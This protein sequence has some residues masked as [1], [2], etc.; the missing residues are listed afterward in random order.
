MRLF[1]DFTRCECGCASL[2]KE[3]VAYATYRKLPNGSIT[4]F[5]ELPD[6]EETHFICGCCNK[7]IH[8]KKG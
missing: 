4:D 7:T 8:I 3:I 1:E 2:K 5:F 6:R